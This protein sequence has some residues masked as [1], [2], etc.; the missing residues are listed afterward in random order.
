MAW[1]MLSLVLV[2]VY[3]N[4]GVQSRVE[5]P[6]TMVMLDIMGV[7]FV[8]DTDFFIMDECVKSRHDVWGKAQGVL[9]A[10]GK[11]LITT[12]G[13]YNLKSASTSST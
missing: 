3:E 7:L 6:I 8:D 5:A 1:L 11:L 2:V 13:C 12:R 9:P 4:L 10:Q